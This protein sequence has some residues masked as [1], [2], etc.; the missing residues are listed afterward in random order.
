MSDVQVR[1][2]EIKDIRKNLDI[3]NDNINIVDQHVAFVD[4]KVKSVSNEL[5][6][7]KNILNEYI[8]EAEKRDNIANAKQDITHIRQEMEKRF[9]HYDVV[10]RTMT[11]ILQANDLGIVK[12][13]DNK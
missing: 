5:T 7:I 6:D 1:Y 13:T 12:K 9:G 11:G 2:E 3:L 10:R 4:N 8:A